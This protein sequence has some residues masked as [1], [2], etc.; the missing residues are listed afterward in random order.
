MSWVADAKAVITNKIS[1]TANMLMGVCPEAMV[2][3][4]GLGMVNVSKMNAMLMSTC[5]PMVHHRLVRMMSTNGLQK[6]LMVHGRYSR[7]VNSAIC[8]FGTPIL[9]NINTEILFTMK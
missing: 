3:A 5:I 8:P 4:S 1:V 7:L 2:A 9:A 6:G